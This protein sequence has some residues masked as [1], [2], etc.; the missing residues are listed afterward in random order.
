MAGSLLVWVETRQKSALDLRNLAAEEMSIVDRLLN[1]KP[2]PPAASLSRMKSNA[3]DE[4]KAFRSC[5]RW[6]G[7]D[8]STASSAALSWTIFFVLTIAV[9][10]ISHFVL[11]FSA[12]RRPYDAALQLSLSSA[13]ALAF[14]CLSSA[15]HR[16]GLRRLLFLD[17]LRRES[18]RVHAGYTAQL[19]R[20]FRILSVLVTPCLVAEFAYKIWWYISGARRITF[21]GNPAASDAVAF[22]LELASWIYRTAIFLL[23]CVLFRLICQL[24]ILRLQDFAAV[25]REESEVEAVLRQHLRIKK[26]LRVTSHR[27]RSFVII[28]LVL[29]TASQLTVLFL[30]TRHNADVR[31][32]NTG[33]LAN[34][35]VFSNPDR[36]SS[37][38]VE[39]PIFAGS[40]WF[41]AKL[42]FK[43]DQTDHQG[44]LKV[45]SDAI[46]IEF[47]D[48][49]FLVSLQLCSIT[50]VTG[51]L[52]CLRSAA[53]ITHKAQ[54]LTS[55][56][57][58][59]HVCATIDS[60]S[61]DPEAPCNT[62]LEEGDDDDD[63][64]DKFYEE[65]AKSEDELEDTK[66][67]HPQAN[68]ITFQKR[69]ALG[70][71]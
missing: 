42:I 26:Q 71:S 16:Y 1:P 64:D 58:K 46:A 48:L 51:L 7:V 52:I 61:H 19:G 25:F 4:L 13:A 20:S 67:V 27:F 24:Q 50:L 44:R 18:P 21:L 68:T 35:S 65:E 8:H 9:P 15:Y 10:S 66:L 2:Q 62:Q 12:H 59:W 6:M 57:A 53:K 56:A 3:A 11:A 60:F 14:L 32:F 55:H 49:N 28:C 39:L 70:S 41:D 36:F 54:A 40:I 37:S 5:L 33:E 43:L 45:E 47:F 34:R 17:E 30:A 63:V 38:S 29:V 23:V 69:Q 22:A 31:L